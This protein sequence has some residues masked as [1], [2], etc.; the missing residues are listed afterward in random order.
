M[1][2]VAVSRLLQNDRELGARGATPEPLTALLVV[3]GLGLLGLRRR[4][5]QAYDNV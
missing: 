1:A 3:L 5:R 4:G 2:E